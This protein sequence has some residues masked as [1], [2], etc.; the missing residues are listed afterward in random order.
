[1][2]R[3]ALV[4]GIA[5]YNN[6][7][8]QLPKA[9]TDAENI[10]RVLREHGGFEVQP[11]P[12]KLIESENRWYVAPDKKLTGKELGSA[13]RK[14][15]LEK[16]KN[17]EA[18]IYFAGHGFEAATL[19]GQQKGYLATS[20]CTSDGQNAIAFDDFNDLIR[21]SQLASLVVLLDCCYAG[22]F[23]E[24]SFLRSSFP[25]FNS[26]QDYCLITASREFE[27]AR[28]DIEG[29]IFTQAILKGLSHDK[30]DE[31][32]GE[33]NAT[34]LFSF[35][36]R[37]L[38]QSGQEPIYM[39]GGRSIPLVW[40]PP[41]NP[42][43]LSVVREECPYRGLEAFDKQH[44]QFFFGRKK[45]VEDIL[46]KLAQAQFV[47]IIG[48]SG[49]GKSSVVRAGLIPQ[50]ENNGWRILDPIK[51]G[52]EPLGKLRAA[53]E[54]FFQ[55]PKEIQQLYEFIHNHPDG[56]RS[57]IQR[58]PGSE[59]FLLVVDQF[60]EVFTLCPKEEERRRFIDLLTQVVELS[61]ATSL[62]SLRLVVVTTMRADFLEPCLS[63]PS[64]TQVIQ[65]QAVYMPPLVGA[66]LEQAIALPANLQ[67]YRFEDGLLGEIIQDV[68]KEQGSLPLLQF[69]L[70][71]LWEKRDSQK[72][73]LTVEQ[74][75]A[76]SGVLG[77]LDRHAENI[78]H[79]FT[80]QEQESVKRIFLKL[81]RTGEGEKDTRQRQPKAKLLAI[82]GENEISFVLDELIQV[83]LLVTGQED[84]QG[85]AWVDL[86]HE[87][88]M[89]G[90]QRFA[91]WRQKN[92]ELRRLSDR[93]EDALQ[94]WQKNPQDE[95]LM[96]GGLLVQV[97]EKWL[98]LEPDLDTA[99]RE[100]YQHSNSLEQDRIAALERGLIESKLREQAARVLNLLPVQ[101]LDGLVLAIQSIGLNLEKL[102]EQILSSVQTSLHTAMKMGREF[103]IQGHGDH[104]TSVAFSP[105]GQMIVSGSKDKTVRLW[106]LQG[107][108]IGQPFRGHGDHVTSV[109]FSPDG[110]MI[111]SGSRD[112]TVR[113]WGLYGNLIG[114]P[115]RG[116]GDHVTSVAFSPDG[117]MIASGSRD[118]TVRLWD[119]QGN[120]IGHPFRGH[121][122]Y[123]T[124][125]AF[126]PD[127][128]MIASGS[129]DNTLRLW[130]LQGN[131]IGK[132]FQGHEENYVTSDY[133]TD[134]EIIVYSIA[135]S[136]DGQMIV[137][138]GEDR[139]V[140][141][142]DLQGNPI[143]QPFRGHENDVTSVAFSPDG[144]M[145]V[146]GSFDNTVRLW[147]LQGYP[148]GQ[149]FRGHENSVRSV[150]F[151]PNGQAIVSGSWDNTVR[152]WD[153]QDH[154]IGQ[155][156]RGHK[157]YVTFVAFSPNGQM[158]A[159]GSV[160]KTVQL[161]NLQGYPIGHPFQGHEDVVTSVA[162]SPNGEMIVS[163]SWD[164][165]VRLWDLQGNPIAQPFRGHENSVTSVAFSPNGETIV[166]GSWDNTV[167]LWDLQ[168]NPIAQPFRG[169]ENSVTSVAF[170]PNGE[171]IVSGSVD[172]TVR[173]WNLQGHLIGQP[174]EGHEDSV[175]S[176]AF[177]PDGQII[178]SASA[179]K[180]VRLSD[181][182]GYPI[183]QPF[184]GHED[185]VYSAVISRDGQMIVSASADKTV[186]LWDL[187]GYP[188]GQPFEGHEHF[189][190]SI[191]FSPD[192]QMIV[193]GSAD[194]TVRLWRVGW[195]ACLQVCCDRLRYHPIFNNPQTEEAK[196]AC[197][198]CRKYVWDA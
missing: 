177:S 71:E 187:D 101:T 28:E 89:E 46:Q 145:I 72:H 26:K 19:T 118:K 103:L 137:S 141:L 122:D 194:K 148:I 43:D 54:P 78:Y 116:H 48:A 120:P 100:F 7:R 161:S 27:R 152:L 192:G 174:F 14:F 50:L 62:Q 147:D 95:N 131:P 21:E 128:Q 35:I 91:Q 40:Y 133:G 85:D 52:I 90:W 84:Q 59:R 197:E 92:R 67:G 157:D 175:T 179:D 66:E 168:G 39:G 143:G 164:N 159:S 186:R 112:K 37:E 102:P 190:N 88:L 10:A 64:L 69:A 20:D 76:M 171:M 156:F 99:A 96:M 158:I 198:T 56:L 55:R 138:G 189:I 181:L 36:S 163:G 121:E 58:L 180:T 17:H 127:G 151:S 61:D 135:F 75:R 33:V 1:M 2:A 80:E 169:H 114:H 5:N 111:V 124:S 188:I 82:G 162:F 119:L 144:Q 53:F 13:L 68:G 146:S 77:A 154:S 140:R 153:L 31:A 184:E 115:F 195:W 74:Y 87:A 79:S 44:A 185:V 123:V 191:A 24:N 22:S 51:P 12:A 130:D 142:W 173:L 63:Y 42:V 117:Q 106:N 38:K 45:V 65:N 172:K 57:V 4:I 8:K 113:L 9:V 160:D 29:G 166:S 176:V 109:A 83:R 30:A 97:R 134:D 170:S 11:L 165:T 183:G 15:L 149:L 49:S 41:K 196:A 98:E 70:T 32:T 73:Q 18:L 178:V 136:P 155:P 34:D 167:R 107:H 16:A 104:V 193:S 129:W 108:P 182:R 60:E 132:P 125:V 47:P 94:E 110:Q 86:A 25:V 6:F 105:D 93:V 126:S 23:L 3:Y 150:A 81:V 139:T